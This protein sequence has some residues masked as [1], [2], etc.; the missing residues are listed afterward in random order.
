MVI[1]KDDSAFYLGNST[2][3]STRDIRTAR[4]SVE[5]VTSPPEMH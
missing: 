1:N 4:G 2:Q 3:Q 5:A